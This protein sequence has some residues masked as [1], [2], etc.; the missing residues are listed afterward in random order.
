M[1]DIDYHVS[2]IL[3][4]L[5]LVANGAP[6]L[7]RY[8]LRRHFTWPID[9]GTA[10]GDGQRLFGRTKT[11]RGVV[12]SLLL[13][14]LAGGLL[15]L[16]G[17]SALLFACLCMVGDLLTSFFKRRLGMPSS[18][19]FFLIDQLLETLLP[20]LVFMPVWGYSMIE[21]GVTILGFVLSGWIIS[22]V[23][24]LLGVRRHPH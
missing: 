17:F 16:G 21:A 11:Y 9:F 8:M 7:A 23:L 2:G 18:A 13:T 12:A 19:R 4:L 24:F 1:A 14:S 10:L 15:G 5:L 3:I 20:V 6:V 22:P